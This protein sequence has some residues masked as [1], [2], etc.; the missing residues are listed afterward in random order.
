MVVWSTQTKENSAH[1]RP[2][3]TFIVYI[4]FD[5]H[6]IPLISLPGWFGPYPFHLLTTLIACTGKMNA[7][8]PSRIRYP[9]S[10]VKI[11]VEDIQGEVQLSHTINMTFGPYILERTFQGPERA[12]CPSHGKEGEKKDIPGLFINTDELAGNLTV[13]WTTQKPRVTTSQYECLSTRPPGHRPI[14]PAPAPSSASLAEWM[15]P[16]S[17]TPISGSFTVEKHKMG[18]PPVPRRSAHST[19]PRVGRS[20]AQRGRAAVNTAPTVRTSSILPYSHANTLSWMTS[21]YSVPSRVRLRGIHQ[22]G[23]TPGQHHRTS[24]SM[25]SRLPYPTDEPY[26]GAP[27]PTTSAQRNDSMQNYQLSIQSPYQTASG[28][29]T[30]SHENND[31][32]RS[33][34]LIFQ[35][36]VEDISADPT[37]LQDRSNEPASTDFTFT[38]PPSTQ[39]T[40]GMFSPIPDDDLNYNH[41]RMD[42]V[43]PGEADFADMQWESLLFRGRQILANQ[44]QDHDSEDTLNA[45]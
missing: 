7:S 33:Q 20:P 9:F 3:R 22:L 6:Q 44:D 13:K 36:G 34:P 35:F 32:S 12:D 18:P 42:S 38:T 30:P 5:I 31:L 29:V 43:H 41:P 23:Q 45:E 19:D 39:D 10:G 11:A 4:R 28:P 17:F 15:K 8:H 21:P 26:P 16:R 14:P 25:K 1:K 27:S 40:I 24:P 2:H 37:I